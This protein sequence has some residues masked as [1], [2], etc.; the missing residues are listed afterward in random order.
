M[1]RLPHPSKRWCAR[2]P[3][4]WRA[5]ACP[6]DRHAN[7]APSCRYPPSCRRDYCEWIGAAKR[8]E[9]RARR[10]E[11]AIA[12]RRDGKRRNWKHA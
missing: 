6:G 4:A 3:I 9:T 2:R 5:A 11:E 8:P 10:T 12:W 1:S 7:P